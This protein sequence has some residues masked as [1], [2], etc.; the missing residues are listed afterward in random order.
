[1]LLVHQ[2]LALSSRRP[3]GS[4]A[5]MPRPTF[6]VLRFRRRTLRSSVGERNSSKVKELATKQSSGLLAA[7]SSLMLAYRQLVAKLWTAQL[8]FEEL[9][10]DPTSFPVK[11]VYVVRSDLHSLDSGLKAEVCEAK[12]VLPPEEIRNMER[13]IKRKIGRGASGWDFLLSLQICRMEELRTGVSVSESRSGPKESESFREDWQRF[14]D[15]LC[16]SYRRQ[17]QSILEHLDQL[18]RTWEREATR[19]PLPCK[20]EVA[21]GHHQRLLKQYKELQRTIGAIRGLLSVKEAEVMR[22]QVEWRVVPR[23]QEWKARLKQRFEEEDGNGKTDAC[24]VSVEFGDDVPPPIYA[25]IPAEHTAEPM[26][27]GAFMPEDTQ[28]PPEKD[29]QDVSLPFRPTTFSSPQTGKGDGDA[30]AEEAQRFAE[31][32]TGIQSPE[33]NRVGALHGAEGLEEASRSSTA[34]SVEVDAAGRGVVQFDIEVD[35][36]ERIAN[37]GVQ[38]PQEPTDQDKVAPQDVEAEKPKRSVKGAR[39][40]HKKFLDNMRQVLG[41]EHNYPT[42]SSESGEESLEEQIESEKEPGE[43]SDQYGLVLSSEREMVEKDRA[44][45]EGNLRPHEGGLTSHTERVLFGDPLPG[46]RGELAPEDGR[47]SSDRVRGGQKR[48]SRGPSPPATSDWQTSNEFEPQTGEAESEFRKDLSGGPTGLQTNEQR[49]DTPEIV[50]VAP[51]RGVQSIEHPQRRMSLESSRSRLSESSTASQSSTQTGMSLRDGLAGGQVSA[52]TRHRGKKTHSGSPCVCCQGG[53]HLWQCHRFLGLS[54]LDRRTVVRRAGAC[55]VCLRPSHETSDCPQN[56]WNRC[57]ILG[58]YGG[59]HYLLHSEVAEAGN[60]DW[61]QRPEATTSLV[62]EGPEA[63]D[64][65]EKALPEDSGFS[66]ELGQLSERMDGL[67]RASKLWRDVLENED[68][69]LRKELREAL[70]SRSSLELE[71]RA[72]KDR[73]GF[74]ESELSAQQKASASAGVSQV[75][76]LGPDPGSP[77][78]D[79][80]TTGHPVRSAAEEDKSDDDLLAE[81]EAYEME[82]GKHVTSEEPRGQE[83]WWGAIVEPLRETPLKPEPAEI[84][85]DLIQF[86][87]DLASVPED[88]FGTLEVEDQEK[89]ELSMLLE[90]FTTEGSWD[91]TGEEFLT[92]PA[93]ELRDERPFDELLTPEEGENLIERPVTD[94]VST[95]SP[96]PSPSCGWELISSDQDTEKVLHRLAYIRRFINSCWGKFRPMSRELSTVELFL[97]RGHL[98]ELTGQRGSQGGESSVGW[99]ADSLH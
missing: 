1:L 56:P 7:R 81:L 34:H 22:E 57:R 92:L 17:E 98:Y 90:E 87:E 18:D 20:A 47:E 93:S 54:S 38:W 48:V 55:F 23:F 79:S 60:R 52:R 42:A 88:V 76:C 30:D 51:T 44:E 84:I 2:C 71:V 27:T 26:Q 72:L 73:V 4:F 10:E 39:E 77:R 49:V 75:G 13:R 9:V 14:W 69:G 96:A 28:E 16:S 31:N 78:E 65:V 85:R 86:E 95:F 3:G 62:Q 32:D 33:S 19:D 59:H 37:S 29:A 70:E 21:R 91:C 25:S 50:E 15:V 24:V 83:V 45:K 61:S 8:V 12:V 6:V 58:C 89:E 82:S 63:D 35:T 5:N 66:Q 94:K 41:T 11:T 74:L 43:V 40:R 99:E 67:E 68:D 97:A 64:M 80:L 36:G 53:H 46:E